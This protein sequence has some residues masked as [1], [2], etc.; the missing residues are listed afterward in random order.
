MGATRLVIISVSI[1]GPTAGRRAAVA[2][3][4]NDGVRFA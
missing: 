1:A 2:L 3:C 4:K